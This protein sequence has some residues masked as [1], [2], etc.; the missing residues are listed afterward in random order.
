MNYNE[1][2]D[3]G[4]PFALSDLSKLL[5]NLSATFVLLL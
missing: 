3:G 4:N 1:P 5:H 2:S